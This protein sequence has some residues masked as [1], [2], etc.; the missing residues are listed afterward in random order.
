MQQMP[1]QQ[2]TT[3]ILVH[4]SATLYHFNN[5]ATRYMCESICIFCRCSTTT[6]V[7]RCSNS[8]HSISIFYTPPKK[9]KKRK[10]V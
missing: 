4:A 3:S 1:C 2:Q 9:Q 5:V 8:L 10:Y 6:T 7:S